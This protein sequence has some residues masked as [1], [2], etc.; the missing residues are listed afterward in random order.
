MSDGEASSVAVLAD[1]Q[2]STIEILRPFQN[3]EQVYQ[4]KDSL[5]PIAFPGGKD[6]AARAG[7]P[8]FDPN[9]IAGVPV[10]QGAIIQ[11]S[12][13]MTIA[14]NP[15]GPP[16]PFVQLYQYF[17]VWRFRTLHDFR[18]PP[19]PGLV[20]PYHLAIQS[21]GQ[22]DTSAPPGQQ[23][24]I[25]IPASIRS[26]L[27]QQ[28]EP[29]GLHAN[30]FSNLRVESIVPRLD[31]SAVRAPL[32]AGGGVG[33]LEQGVLD[34]AVFGETAKV[35]SYQDFLITAAGDEMILFA[36][37]FDPL[38]P[39]NKWD[40]NSATADK[41]FAN[42]YGNGTGQSFPNIGIEVQYGSAP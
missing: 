39:T 2:F 21:P 20:T 40:F 33:V 1:A 3:F 8:G 35:P 41:G 14:S 37:R 24:R 36:I 5:I 23:Q 38:T 25:V 6:P 18:D 13:P 12:I 22:P 16:D 9:L 17:V 27:F 30:T 26:I 42:I 28:P 7:T 29:A 19:S 32:L 4:G 31:P 34:P 11:I 15:P 10:P